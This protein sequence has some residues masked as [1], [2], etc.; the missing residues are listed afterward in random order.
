M[1]LFGGGRLETPCFR[2][3]WSILRGSVR[4]GRRF[5]G[6]LFAPGAAVPV[7]ALFVRQAIDEFVVVL[8]RDLHRHVFAEGLGIAFQQ[9][10]PDHRGGEREDD[11][12]DEAAPR[13][14]P[15]RH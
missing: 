4:L 12:A 10:G 2:V 3:G 8:R 15:R 1:E 14:A 6:S 11:R 5:T 9:H 13:A 7:L